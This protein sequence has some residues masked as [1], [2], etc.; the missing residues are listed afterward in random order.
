MLSWAE[1]LILRADTENYYHAHEFADAW[2]SLGTGQRLISSWGYGHSNLKV[3]LTD[4]DPDVVQV[5]GLDD[6][7]AN[8]SEPITY[9]DRYQPE[10]AKYNAA[11]TRSRPR[12]VRRAIGVPG[13]RGQIQETPQ[14]RRG[15]GGAGATA[16]LLSG[17]AAVDHPVLLR[18]GRDDLHLQHRGHLGPVTR[19]TSRTSPLSIGSAS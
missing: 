6:P 4:I 10:R 17:A 11:W 12:W 8:L 14:R 7:E 5:F 16:G 13:G 1:G 19:A 15:S 18:A 9:I 3:D 2:A